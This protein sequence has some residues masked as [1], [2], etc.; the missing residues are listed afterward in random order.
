MADY[1]DKMAEVMAK[2][3]AH[4]LRWIRQHL[5]AIFVCVVALVLIFIGGVVLWAATLKIPDLTS[6]ENQKIAPSVQ[7]YDRTW[8]TLL[9]NVGGADRSVVPLASISANIQEAF[10]ASEDPTFYQNAGI[11]PKSL[12]RALYVD[13][14]SLGAVQ[15][16]ST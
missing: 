13:L 11:D 2:F 9:Y 6:L 12:L 8:T 5:L 15:G 14:T 4:P 1:Y 7:I 10:V 16:G 3:L